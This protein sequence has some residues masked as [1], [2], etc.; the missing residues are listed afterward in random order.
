M[1]LL[2]V[3]FYNTTAHA[4]LARMVAARVT[5]VVL[6]RSTVPAVLAAVFATASKKN[7]T[8]CHDQFRQGAQEFLQ[9]KAPEL[10]R[11]LD[12]LLKEFYAQHPELRK[13]NIMLQ[14]D[15]KLAK[16]GPVPGWFVGERAQATERVAVRTGNIWD[17]DDQAEKYRATGFRGN[18][19]V[20]FWRW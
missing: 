6:A 17:V 11:R 20:P 8:E 15:V 16:F 13:N 1:L 14:A 10:Q 9:D 4:M 3:S 7:K 12:D 2:G 19:E 18:K 5:R